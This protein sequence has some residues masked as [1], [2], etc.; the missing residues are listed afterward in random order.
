ML[1]VVEGNYKDIYIV[2]KDIYAYKNAYSLKPIKL[3]HLV[4]DVKNMGKDELDTGDVGTAICI[5]LVDSLAGLLSLGIMG[6]RKCTTY[7]L[8]VYGENLVIQTNEKQAKRLLDV[9]C[10]KFK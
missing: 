8:V 1:Q 5:G 9:L 7:Q 10:L 4:T 3:T 6:H 2:G